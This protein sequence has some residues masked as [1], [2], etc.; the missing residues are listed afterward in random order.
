MG[1][2]AMLGSIN[3]GCALDL[4]IIKANIL[5]PVGPIVGF[6]S[7]FTLMPLVIF[8]IRFRVTKNGITEAAMSRLIMTLIILF[9]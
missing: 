5:R 7:Q 3:M 6:I 8:M 4:S 1:G 2:A 9:F